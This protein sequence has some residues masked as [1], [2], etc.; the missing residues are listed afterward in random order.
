MKRLFDLLFSAIAL[1]VFGVPMAVIA[2]LLKFREKH[3]VLFRQ[4]RI[5]IAKVPFMILKFQT[6]ID[7]KPTPTGVILRKTGLD[8]LPQFFNVLKGDMSIVGP[9]ALTKFDI[10]RL[11]WNDEFH[12]HRWQIKPGITGFAQ[13][14]GGQ[15]RK[16]SWFFDRLYF[17]CHTMLIDFGIIACSFLMNLFGKTRVR[18]I[19]FQK[20]NL[21]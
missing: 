21:K 6:L 16:T 5:G 7:E 10:D 11:G 2:L 17:E 15:H 1:A 14:Y 19:L 13:L 9:R 8:E 20:N 3:A 12:S 18:R 4:E